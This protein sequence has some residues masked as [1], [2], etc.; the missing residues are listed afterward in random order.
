[1]SAEIALDYARRMFE[2]QHVPLPPLGF[3]VDWAD[4]PSR[5]KLYLDTVKVPLPE[6][7]RSMPPVGIGSALRIAGSAQAPGVPDLGVLASML[8]CYGLTGRRTEPNWNDDSHA[9]IRSDQAV[10]ARPTASGGGMYPAESY[11]V[12]GRAGPLPPGVYHYDTAHHSLDRLSTG[13]RCGALAT[14]T[15]VRAELYAVVTLRFWKNAFKY[16]SFSYHVVTQD[17]GALLASWRLV[18]A[19]HDTPVE[20][21]LWFDEA[22]V[23][24]VLDVDGHDEAPFLVLPLGR[25]DTDADEAVRIQVRA[26]H[27]VWEKSRRVRSFE[28]VSRVHAAA[29]VGDLPRPDLARAGAISG[30]PADALVPLPDPA[31]EAADLDVRDSLRRRRSSFGLLNARPPLDA[32]DLAWV[33]SS[34]AQAGLAGTDV[35][36]APRGHGWTGQWVL[37][38]SVAGL[39]RRAYR[40][41]AARGGLVAGA[42]LDVNLQRLYALTNYSLPEVAAV[43]VVTGRLDALVEAYGA[44]GYRMLSIEVGQAA[45]T[46]YLAATARGLGVGAVLGLDNIGID[47]LLGIEGTGERSMVF[48]L[49]G[50]ERAPRLGYDHSLYRSEGGTR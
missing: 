26:P 8:G 31:P 30:D 16:N 47:E 29:L 33:L 20:P 50:H 24:A 42:A 12:V 37:A 48:M 3:Q 6:P 36:P 34:V 39:E 41:D 35:A 10:W 13:D 7:F 2:R 25:T 5:H 1:M 18:L 45:Q 11:L 4:Q 44:R 28:L 14:A 43:L 17:V 32:R 46:A 23:G 21:V 27:R 19:T 9:K 49:L 38:N 15:G 22:A 40:Y